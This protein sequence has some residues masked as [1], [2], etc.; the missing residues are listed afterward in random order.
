MIFFS[1]RFW[2]VKLFELRF[3][4]LRLLWKRN[5]ADTNVIF[6]NGVCIFSPLLSLN[7]VFETSW[8]VIILSVLAVGNSYLHAVKQ[9]AEND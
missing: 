3:T 7:H 6:L 2:G 9:V 1:G 8:N 5:E 4:L